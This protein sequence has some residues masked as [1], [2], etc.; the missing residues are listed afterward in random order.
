MSV[1]IKDSIFSEFEW[2][3]FKTVTGPKQLTRATT[4]LESVSWPALEDV[5]IIR[6]SGISCRLTA[7]IGLGY[8]HMVRNIQFADSTNLV[9]RLRLPRFSDNGLYPDPDAVN[10]AI[11]SEI[12]TLHAVAEHTD[13]VVPRVYASG[14]SPDCGVGAPYVLVNCVEGNS[15]LDLGLEIPLQYENDLFCE[16]AGI[17]VIHLSCIRLP[18]IGKILSINEDGTYEQGAIPGI[19][20]PFDTA[21]EYYTAWSENV[22]FGLEEERLRQASGKYA[23]EVV[24]STALFKRSIADLANKISTPINNRGP[25]P[26]IRGDFGHH[27]ILVDDD[28]RV[29]GVIDF[30]YTFAGPVEI[31]ASFPKNLFP[32]P[33]VADAPWNY[34]ADGNAIP[35]DLVQTLMYQKNYIKAVEM[36]VSRLGKDR[37]LSTAM[38]DPERQQL[39]KALRS[40]REG[41]AAFYGNLTEECSSL[42]KKGN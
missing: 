33:R 41:V 32:M 42:M 28:Y 37:I 27:N 10:I 20:G 11:R 24:A 14:T 2:D 38:L 4:F 1:T 35:Q 36:E 3:H 31:A 15:G 26:S 30:E 9:A 18:R 16:M 22:S 17:N 12:C 8:N 29:K 34:D 7:D 23:E 19:G 39:G 5:E 40:F 25:F 13:I 6:R 21:A